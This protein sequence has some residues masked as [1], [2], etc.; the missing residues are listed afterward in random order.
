MVRK[1]IQNIVDTSFCYVQGQRTH[2]ARN[3]K[4]TK[5]KGHFIPQ[6]RQRAT[7]FEPEKISVIFDA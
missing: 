6:Q 3:K 1:T 7:F 2:S 5:Y 4:D